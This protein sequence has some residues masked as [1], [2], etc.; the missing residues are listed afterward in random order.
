MIPVT[1][2]WGQYRVR[3]TL[4]LL[5]EPDYADPAKI[6]A[7]IHAMALKTFVEAMEAEGLEIDHERCTVNFHPLDVPGQEE[8]AQKQYAWVFSFPVPFTHPNTPWSPT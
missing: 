1:H 3:M 5:I 7:A 2:R 6:P 8:V 4:D